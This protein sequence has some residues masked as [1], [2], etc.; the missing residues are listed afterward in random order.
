M[1]DPVTLY[2]FIIMTKSTLSRLKKGALVSQCL[3]LQNQVQQ[4]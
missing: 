4:L 2:A 1:V 3:E